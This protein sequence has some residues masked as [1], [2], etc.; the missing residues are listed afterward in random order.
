VTDT[1][2]AL[3]E[4]TA[5][6]SERRYRPDDLMVSL[7]EFGEQD[8]GR[9]RAVYDFAQGTYLD[10][11]A[12]EDRDPAAAMARIRATDLR[13]LRART[14]RLGDDTDDTPRVRAIIHDVRGGTTAAFMSLAEL[15]LDQ[16]VPEERQLAYLQ[17]LVWLVR[18]EAKV[19]RGV[20]VDLDPSMREPDTEHKPHSVSDL[21]RKWD[22]MRYDSGAGVVSLEVLNSLGAGALANR[23]LEASAIDRVAYNFLNNAARFAASERVTIDLRP[24]P[25]QRMGRVTVVNDLPADETAWLEACLASDPAALF[26]P[27]VSRGGSG[28]GLG[29]C[30]EIVG[31]AFELTPDQAVRERVIGYEVAEG[32][33][34]AWFCWPT[35]EI[36]S[37]D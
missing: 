31:A 33:F 32:R 19:M 27:D 6:V 8:R 16:E 12:S 30:A 1:I 4:P 2:A 37:D 17:Q 29:A 22:G 34:Y 18:D 21:V 23:C 28:I 36:E 14:D 11:L 35:A 5:P 13:A 9:L 26:R 7:A 24:I 20:V 15:L 3:P 25:A 10:W